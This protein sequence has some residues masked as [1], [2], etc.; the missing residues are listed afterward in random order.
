MRRLLLLLL[1]LALGT[2]VLTTPAHAGGPTSVLITEPGA[3]DATALYYADAGYA[4]LDGMVNGAVPLDGEPSDLGA[5]TLHLTWMAHDV[6]PWRTQQLYVEAAGGPVLATYDAEG[7][8]TS[9]ARVSEGK[10]LASLVDQ[11]LRP[12]AEP[13]LTAV[14]VPAAPEAAATERVVTE[15]AWW[16]LAG[17]RWLVL[18]LLVGAGA[19]LLAG[20]VR[21]PRTEPRQALVDLDPTAEVLTR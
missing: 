1:V 13:D 8:T 11:L 5:R 16:S 7:G 15:T 10:A 3:G 14:D 18:G 2:V 21:S 6:H 17:W 19:V 4:E 9:W 20:R 12:G